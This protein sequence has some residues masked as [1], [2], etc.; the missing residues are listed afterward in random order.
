MSSNTETFTFDRPETIDDATYSRIVFIR[1]LELAVQPIIDH[2]MELI[3]T[4]RRLRPWYRGEHDAME[5]E[6]LSTLLDPDAN[7]ACD[8]LKAFIA[9]VK[10]YNPG[11]FPAHCCKM[12]E[13]VFTTRYLIRELEKCFDSPAFT[14]AVTQLGHLIFTWSAPNAG[15]YSFYDWVTRLDTRLERLIRS[16]AD[17]AEACRRRERE[18]DSE[19]AFS[20]LPPA[21]KMDV[22]NAADDVKRAVRKAKRDAFTCDALTL[23]QC[24]ALCVENG[25]AVVLDTENRGV[26][27]KDRGQ[28][29]VGE[30]S[31]LAVFNDVTYC[32]EL[33]K[34]GPGLLALGGTARFG[35][36]GA[37]SPA[38]FSNVLNFVE[39]SF[40]PLSM[41]CLDGVAATFGAGV[42]L[43]YDLKPADTAFRAKG[44][45]LENAASALA[46][47]DAA[48]PV[49]FACGAV[50][51]DGGVYK[52]GL[53]TAFSEATVRAFAERLVI[54]KPVAAGSCCV[55]KVVEQVT[56]G[57]WTLSVVIRPSGFTVIIR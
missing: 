37:S 57:L 45:V 17:I 22:D 26:L 48:V 27:V 2:N 49:T 29:I 30:A 4:V 35:V 36:D 41:R 34:T 18:R 23:E 46:F 54:A 19:I 20:A 51:F 16:F 8:M 55:E 12:R 6:L 21:T 1:P 5:P 56:G 40:M 9:I 50:Q 11:E 13:L 44:V 10:R 43:V 28:M 52:V 47:A 39:C 7:H 14:N 25:N 53:L 33:R 38:A 15:M 3:G 32:G 31:S 42:S 24:G